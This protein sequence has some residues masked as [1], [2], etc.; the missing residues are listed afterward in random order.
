MPTLSSTIQ[1]TRSK[2]AIA[3]PHCRPSL[4]FRV[5]AVSLLFLPFAP[6]F[7]HLSHSSILTGVLPCRRE[8]LTISGRLS[9][10]LKERHSCEPLNFFVCR[11]VLDSEEVCDGSRRHSPA[12]FP[13][14]SDPSHRHRRD[15]PL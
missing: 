12:L 10:L 3:E 7:G 14:I 9:I 11:C 5:L 13:G 6:G 1:M 15:C 4:S 2:F 8:P